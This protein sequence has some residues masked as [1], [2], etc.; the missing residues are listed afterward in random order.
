MRPVTEEVPDNPD[1][2]WGIALVAVGAIS[3][4]YGFDMTL[5]HLAAETRPD[6][7]IWPLLLLAA[8][9]DTL[10]IVASWPL[11]H[12][13]MRTQ[14]RKDG[15]VRLVPMAQWGVRALI[16]LVGAGI[17][18]YAYRRI[19][20]ALPLLTL[21][22]WQGALAKG[23]TDA[24]NVY[25]ALCLLL[26]AWRGVLALCLDIDRARYDKTVPDEAP[27]S[28]PSASDRDSP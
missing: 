6:H 27:A 20:Q 12:R 3:L 7:V 19:P 24:L 23:A 11:W 22:G 28:A 9:G 13:L 4:V 10:L 26:C 17:A 2:G 15:P 1:A 8:L 14:S 18:F 21:S 5:L 16:A 25:G